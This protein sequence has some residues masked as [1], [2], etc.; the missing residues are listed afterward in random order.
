[1]AIDP[2]SAE[3][4]DELRQG[5]S[6]QCA[7]DTEASW[8]SVLSVP[9]G[10][11]GSA[12]PQLHV[13]AGFSCCQSAPGP[14]LG[15]HLSGSRCSAEVTP[16]ARSPRGHPRA[17]SALRAVAVTRRSRALAPGRAWPSLNRSIPRR[18]NTRACETRFCGRAKPFGDLPGKPI[19]GKRR[20][21]APRMPLSRSTR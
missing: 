9:P 16:V 3:L 6:A 14:D 1:M 19:A 18:P 8:V 12:P 7:A 2:L 11:P 15:L 5:Q 4:E 21:S 10:Q 17:R 13:S 20:S